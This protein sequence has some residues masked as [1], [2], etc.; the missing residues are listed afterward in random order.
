MQAE[1]TSYFVVWWVLF[2]YSPFNHFPKT[3]HLLKQTLSQASALLDVECAHDTRLT[4]LARVDSGH[5]NYHHRR[6]I[7]KI[8]DSRD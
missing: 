8:A 7:P 3:L 5:R 1:T 6:Q 4:N 2:E